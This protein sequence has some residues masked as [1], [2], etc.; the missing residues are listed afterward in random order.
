MIVLPGRESR[1]CVYVRRVGNKMMTRAVSLVVLCSALAA[2]LSPVAF[3]AADDAP[4]NPSEYL[5]DAEEAYIQK[6][7]G[8]YA[9]ARAAL[10]ALKGQIDSAVGGAIFGGGPGPAEMVGNVAAC[11]GSLTAQASV[12]RETPPESFAGLSSTNTAIAARLDGSFGPTFAIV[13][14]EAKNRLLD[15]ARDKFGGFFA[16]VLGVGPA[17]E[18]R[19][20]EITVKL[21]FVASV[22]SEID[23]IRALLDAGQG[24][25][26]AKVKE[27][28]EQAEAGSEFLDWF[29]FD[30]CFIATAAYGTS[31]ADEIDVLR[32]FRDR[33]LLMS[34]AGRDYIAFYYAASPPIAT[35]I[36]R[37]EVLRTV[38]RE[39]V[40]DPIVRLVSWVE[41]LWQSA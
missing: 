3:V 30:E 11:K 14:E 35:F 9:A 27:V 16:G 28:V 41:P 32:A 4:T 5:N 12:F 7:N 23:D 18:K 10:D 24:A 15:A 2:L 6:L 19:E 40:V 36:A 33:V 34:P 29:L 21:R 31:T 38:V 26:N 39:G 8:A 37:H 13:G 25:L 22:N 17:P 1:R 20:S